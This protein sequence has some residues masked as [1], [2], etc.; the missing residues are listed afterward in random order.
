[1]QY[2]VLCPAQELTP[3]ILDAEST[4]SR[5]SARKTPRDAVCA[6]KSAPFAAQPLPLMK[7]YIRG[8]LDLSA[9]PYQ[10]SCECST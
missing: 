8:E 7:L 5:H 10:T 9:P 1:M 2:K 6:T 4:V 3:K